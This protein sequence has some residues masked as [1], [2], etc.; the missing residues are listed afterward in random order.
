[1]AKRLTQKGARFIS[2]TTEYEPF[3]NWDT[4]ENGHTRL[5]EMKANPFA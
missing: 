3:M 1:M 4:H 2:V 5:V